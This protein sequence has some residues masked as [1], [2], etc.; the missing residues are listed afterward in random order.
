MT[1]IVTITPPNEEYFTDAERVM[2][3]LGI[4]PPGTKITNG[5]TIEKHYHVKNAYCFI[6]GQWWRA[7][8]PGF[9]KYSELRQGVSYRQSRITS[10]FFERVK[11]YE[12]N[13]DTESTDS[14]RDCP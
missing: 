7:Q 14:V 5:Y 2:I 4:V 8:G 13:Q 12:T 1:A 10:L 3:A 9:T 11:T 6:D